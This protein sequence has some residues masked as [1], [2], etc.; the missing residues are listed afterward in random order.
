[1]NAE[2]WPR[3]LLS[4]LHCAVV[5]EVEFPFWFG[6]YTEP[7]LDTI[8]I[9]CPH[10]VVG[11]VIAIRNR[12]REYLVLGASSQIRVFA[13]PYAGEPQPRTDDL[14]ETWGVGLVPVRDL[15]CLVLFLPGLSWGSRSVLC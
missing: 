5:W 14:T 7:A 11:F 3:R 8:L 13:T 9:W 1:M 10:N 2:R 15:S 4:Q 6:G 12:Q